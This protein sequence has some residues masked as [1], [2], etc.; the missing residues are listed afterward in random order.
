MNSYIQLSVGN[1]LCIDPP[2]KE[3]TGRT[4]RTNLVVDADVREQTFTRRQMQEV[5]QENNS[6]KHLANLKQTL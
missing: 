6:E 3:Q 2:E 1:L 5:Q 4:T